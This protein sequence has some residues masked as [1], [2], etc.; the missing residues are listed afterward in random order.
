MFSPR[1]ERQ[2][3]EHPATLI[4]GAGR[5]Q[6]GT[7]GDISIRGA[8]FLGRRLPPCDTQVEVEVEGVRVPA[9]VAW[10]KDGA[11]GLEFLEPMERLS[12]SLVRRVIR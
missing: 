8:R 3:I 11:V 10:T 5:M 9:R 7:L 4:H 12:L 2:T 1:A 6:H